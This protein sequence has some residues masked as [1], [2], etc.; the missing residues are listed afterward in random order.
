MVFHVAGVAHIGSR[1]IPVPCSALHGVA[2]SL[3]RNLVL[4][5]R[6][7]LLVEQGISVRSVA[8]KGVAPAAV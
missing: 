5:L 4:L 3:R 6:D 1:F 2:S 8:R 7:W